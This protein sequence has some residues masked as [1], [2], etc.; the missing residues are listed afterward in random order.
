MGYMQ[1]R[2]SVKVDEMRCMRFLEA[3]GVSMGWYHSMDC[4]GSVG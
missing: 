1:K 2:S 4:E 3:G